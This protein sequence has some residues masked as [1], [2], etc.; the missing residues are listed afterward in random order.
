MDWDYLRYVHALAT[1][2]TL[3]RAGEILGVHQTTVLRRLDQIEEQLGVQLFE[4]NRDGLVMTVAGETA[5][6][7]ADRLSHEM[8]NLEQKLAGQSV[9][10]EGKVRLA[11][12][13]TLLNCLL[14]P[15]LSD[16]V[17]VYPGIQLELNTGNEVNSLSRRDV[18]LALHPSNQPPEAM[19]SRRVATIGSAIYSAVQYMDC[20]PDF[21]PKHPE[22]QAWVMPDDSFS[23]LA[24]GARWYQKNLKES[25]PVIRCNSLYSMY[26]LIR[27]GSG[28]GVLPC[29]IG[30]ADPE[31][32]RLSP[33]IKGEGIDLWLLT[34]P[35]LRQGARIRL[36][37]EFLAE[38]LEGVRPL[39]ECE[40]EN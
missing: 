14:N 15:V 6:K 5:F 29:Y 9:R 37:M 38:K 23:H 31:L 16:L 25:Q 2:G 11:T 10:P 17:A 26:S 39:I 13:D 20:N 21:D 8:E 32:Q 30:D 7:E 40:R 35:N 36:V 1:G 18:D 24:T 3:S 19:V 12:T 4:R 22:A 27:A 28:V 34:H 33:P